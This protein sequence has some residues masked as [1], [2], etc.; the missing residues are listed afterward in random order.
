MGTEFDE[1]LYEVIVLRDDHA[2][3]SSSRWACAVIISSYCN[4]GLNTLDQNMTRQ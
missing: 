3:H 2:N 4:C 1:E